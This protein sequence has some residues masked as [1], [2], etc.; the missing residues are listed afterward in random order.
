MLSAL[1]LAGCA[2]DY[3]PLQLERAGNAVVLRG[4][5]DGSS[6]QLLEDFLSENSDITTLVLQNIGGSVDDDANL[7]FGQAVRDLGLNTRV[8]SNGLVASGGTDLFLAG[9]ERTLEPGACI[10]VHEWAAFSFTARDIP[11]DD[12]LHDVYLAYFDAVGIDQEFYWFT[13]RAAPAESMYWM[14]A[15]DAERFGVSTKRTPPL[16]TPSSCDGR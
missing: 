3:T 8:P 10:G 7:Q 2:I 11:R 12:P 1:V 15:K 9:V 13:L 14:T 16:G 6:Q 4:E 5:I